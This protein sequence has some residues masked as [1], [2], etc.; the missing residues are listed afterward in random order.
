MDGWGI[1]PCVLFLL[2]IFRIGIEKLWVEMKVENM[3]GILH[4]LRMGDAI[5]GVAK[6]I[7]QFCF[8]NLEFSPR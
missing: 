5:R 7:L 1:W 4:G 3:F 2:H 6:Y 8:L